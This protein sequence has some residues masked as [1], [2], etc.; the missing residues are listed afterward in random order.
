MAAAAAV[1]ARTGKIHLAR[2]LG[3]GLLARGC[4]LSRFV[5]CCRCVATFSA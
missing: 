1:R 2:A 3:L 4:V 5:V